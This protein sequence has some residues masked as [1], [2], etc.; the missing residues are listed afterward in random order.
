MTFVVTQTATTQDRAPGIL[1]VIQDQKMAA[2]RADAV[3]VGGVLV[4][5]VL[6]RR[7]AFSVKDSASVL[8]TWTNSTMLDD[9]KGMTIYPED[10]TGASE[11]SVPL[12]QEPFLVAHSPPLLPAA[13]IVVQEAI[14]SVSESVSYLLILS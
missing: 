1:R 5:E 7:Y 13:L 11:G 2:V 9:T 14:E 3:E 4:E 12:P 10:T 8:A 6:L